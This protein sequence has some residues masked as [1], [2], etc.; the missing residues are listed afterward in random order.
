MGASDIDGVLLYP[1]KAAQAKPSTVS[2]SRRDFCPDS[3]QIVR[4]DCFCFYSVLIE[5][6]EKKLRFSM[7]TGKPESTYPPLSASASLLVC[8]RGARAITNSWYPGGGGD[9]TQTRKD[10]VREGKWMRTASGEGRKSEAH[11]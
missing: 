8:N 9:R 3:Q 2:P 6:P 7:E 10:K 1:G 11:Q 4:S 5:R